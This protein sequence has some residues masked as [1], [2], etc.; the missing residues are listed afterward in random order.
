MYDHWAGVVYPLGLPRREWFREYA[1]TFD[2]VEINSTFY[3]LPKE[4]VFK[5]WAEKAPE[6]FL[7][8]VKM[9]RVITHLKRLAEAEPFV[10]SFLVRTRLLG[11]YLGPILIQLPPQM[12]CTL[13]ILRNFLE[14]LPEDLTFV[15]EFRHA[16][17]FD[18]RVY[19]ILEDHHVGFCIYDHPEI[20]CPRVTTADVVY[21]RFHG[22][23]R[24][25]G[26]DYPLQVLEDWAHFIAEQTKFGREIYAYFN[27]DVGGYAFKNA[28]ELKQ[29]VVQMLESHSP[30]GGESQ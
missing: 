2:T 25:Y 20:P 17:W 29:L 18:D 11:P 27:N 9:W 26:G 28:K 22:Y 23:R 15:V 14:M 6:G 4:H 24:R 1:K 21:L 13:S 8:A 16:S 3:R 5:S 30:E 19:H 10:E 7:F 12:P